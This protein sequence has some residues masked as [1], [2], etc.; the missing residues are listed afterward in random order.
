MQWAARPSGSGGH[1]D[2]TGFVWRLIL[3]DF[4]DKMPPETTGERHYLRNNWRLYFAPP[5]LLKRGR[6]TARAADSSS[7]HWLINGQVSIEETTLYSGVEN[8]HGEY[9]AQPHEITQLSG[10]LVFNGGTVVIIKED[11]HEKNQIDNIYFV[12]LCVCVFSKRY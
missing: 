10:L 3:F 7:P 9:M 2:Q 1:F 12:N 4:P 6:Y 8:S 11:Y 5:V